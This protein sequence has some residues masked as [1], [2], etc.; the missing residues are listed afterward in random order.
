LQAILAAFLRA[1]KVS[2]RSPLTGELLA[3]DDPVDWDLDTWSFEGA[4]W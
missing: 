4:F 3:A 2:R 1:G